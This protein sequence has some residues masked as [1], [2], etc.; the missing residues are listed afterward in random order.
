MSNLPDGVSDKMIDAQFGDDS[1]RCA[2][3]GEWSEHNEDRACPNKKCLD[4]EVYASDKPNDFR[5]IP[6]PTCKGK[7]QLP[8]CDHCDSCKG[9]DA[10]DSD[11]DSDATYDAAQDAR[12]K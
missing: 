8:A 9:F 5:T 3:G 12:M 4:G 11:D 6:C 1:E 10:L 2:C 7:G